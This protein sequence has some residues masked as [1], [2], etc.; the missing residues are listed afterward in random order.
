MVTSYRNK[1]FE[2]SIGVRYF[3]YVSVI[4]NGRTMRIHIAH[5]IVF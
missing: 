1:L 2:I 5:M 4:C 3:D